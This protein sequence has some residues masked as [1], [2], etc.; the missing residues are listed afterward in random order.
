MMTEE[1]AEELDALEGEDE[2]EDEDQDEGQVIILEK[3]YARCTSR[4]DWFL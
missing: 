3:L 1:E 2:D 4:Y